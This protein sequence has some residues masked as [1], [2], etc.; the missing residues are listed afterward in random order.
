MDALRIRTAKKKRLQSR[1][2]IFGLLKNSNR[3]RIVKK[4]PKLLNR[5]GIFNSTISF[6]AKPK[7][8][9]RT[10]SGTRSVWT[11]TNN[12]KYKTLINQVVQSAKA[13]PKQKETVNQKECALLS[14]CSSI[15]SFDFAG[16]FISNRKSIFQ[17][18]INF[19]LIPRYT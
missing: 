14:N 6:K 16:T 7:N 1:A 8:R 5:S 3:T 4:Q 19:V 18:E 17:I 9:S 2:D 13:K 15:S 12:P 10:N 11:V